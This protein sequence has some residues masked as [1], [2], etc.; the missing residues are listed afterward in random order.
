RML[1]QWRVVRPGLAALH[2][3]HL[4]GYAEP[5]RQMQDDLLLD[6]FFDLA[7][8]SSESHIAKL[9]ARFDITAAMTTSGICLAG[10]TPQGLLCYGIQSR[11][12]VPAGVHGMPGRQAWHFLHL[13]GHFP[14]SVPATMRWPAYRGQRSVTE[15]AGRYEFSNAG[16]RDLL[17]DYITRRAAGIDYSTTET[18]AQALAGLFWSAIETINPAQ[19]DL[20][21]S[22]ATCEQWKAEIS[23]LPDGQPRKNFDALQ[24]TVRSFYLDLQ[25]WAVTE[26]ERRARWAAPCPVR[27]TGLRGLNAR[28][29]RVVEQMA[30]LTRERQPLLPVPAGHA[31]QHHRDLESLLAATREALP[32][33]EF[34]HHGHH[35]RRTSSRHDQDRARA[36]G[37]M[38][39]RVIDQVTGRMFNVALEEDRAFWEWAIVETLRHSGPASRN[40]LS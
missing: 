10:M 9:A 27:D 21:L 13:M 36:E 34:T 39:A 28:R 19:Q 30:G 17:I 6:A 18:L 2:A 23:V 3:N 38:P 7:D 8:A 15:M 4:T 40:C 32:G 16:V 20:R 11:P 26:P 37:A 5:F 1:F 35:C 31:G 22:Q 33:Q 29:R 14:A 12:L 25:S 24:L